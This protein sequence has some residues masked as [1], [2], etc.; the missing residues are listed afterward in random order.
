MAQHTSLS[1]A[2]IQARISLGEE[3]M[4][5]VHA[6][7]RQAGDQLV[8]LQHQWSGNNHNRHQ[9]NMT[10]I[11]ESLQATAN[12]YQQLLDGV[13]SGNTNIQAVDA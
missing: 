8:M 6:S 7:L 2:E 3:H 13:K 5:Q 4:A 1:P 11:I 12:K 10:G 9:Q